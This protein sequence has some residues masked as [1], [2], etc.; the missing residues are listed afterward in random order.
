CSQ[1]TPCGAFAS[2]VDGQCVAKSCGTSTDCGMQS[3]CDAGECQPGCQSS[4]DCYPDEVCDAATASCAAAACRDTSLDCGFREFCDPAAGDCYEASG[5]YCSDCRDDSDCGG[6]G[7]LCLNFG[8][9]GAFCGVTCDTT[10]DCPSGFECLPVGDASGNIISNQCLTYCWLYINDTEGPA[11]PVA[12]AMP[13]L[14]P[15]PV[16]VP[17]HDAETC[18]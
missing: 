4:D 18:P 10:R 1:D 14:R 7:N 13:P 3:Y 12:G 9:P 11:A 15:T 5:Y 16:G 8:A 6:N 17:A 2:C